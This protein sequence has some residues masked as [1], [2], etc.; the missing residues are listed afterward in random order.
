[1]SK[2][3]VPS[4]LRWLGA[5]VTP[6]C[7]Q[8]WTLAQWQ[9]VIRV[10][11]RLRLLGRL[12]E[13]LDRSGLLASVPE[14][15]R[16]H[17]LAEQRYA[18]WRTQQMLW[19]LERLPQMLGRVDYPLVLLKGA[20]YLGQDLGI[21]R[22]RLPS[23]I[24]ILVPKAHIEDAQ[25][26]LLARGWQET[27]LDA[28]DQR[29]YR[30][31]SHELPP[32]RHAL[33]GLELDL[34]HNILPPVARVHVDASLLLADL[35]P[36]LWPGWMVLAPVDQVLH[37]AAHLFHDSDMRDRVRDLVDIDG[38]LRHFGQERVF[39]DALVARARRLGLH[40]SLALA[41]HFCST[42][43]QSP[44]PRDILERSRVQGLSRPEAVW[45]IPLFDRVLRPTDPDATPGLRQTWAA[46][47]LL[48]RHHWGRMPVRL[49]LPHLL[50]KA[51]ARS[52]ASA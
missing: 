38:L 42:W 45:L 39:W 43:L 11:R 31:W 36:S 23:D 24:D 3:G 29:Y 18:R 26:R 7:T 16:R 13:A 49:L 5:L 30:E 19:G 10:S 15:P 9:T 34:H 50:H 32:M 27:E 1:V 6:A 47:T 17:L 2:S 41:M 52:E 12:A 51:R 46:R 25:T 48:L 20:A 22:G 28:H 21:G 33:H 35:R 37:S 44:I 40:Q 4:Q 14:G 8:A